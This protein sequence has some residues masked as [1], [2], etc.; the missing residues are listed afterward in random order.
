MANSLQ[1]F[2]VS[3]DRQLFATLHFRGQAIN[4]VGRWRVKN[5][6]NF[7]FVAVSELGTLILDMDQTHGSPL[8]RHIAPQLSAAFARRFCRD[9]S[10]TLAAPVAGAKHLASI[11]IGG[12]TGKVV[13]DGPDL[14]HATLWFAGEKGHLR[15][16]HLQSSSGSICIVYSRYR[17]DGQP[18]RLILR[19][20]RYNFRMTLDFTEKSP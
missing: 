13:F 16:A 3:F 8:I 14:G 5:P 20:S 9:L 15:L 7:T 2:P 12:H 18:Q 4:L 19:D 6:A 17:A 10:F 1:E 11:V